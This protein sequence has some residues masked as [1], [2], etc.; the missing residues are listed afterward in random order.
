VKAHDLAW[1]QAEQAAT[2][3]GKGLADAKG[4]PVSQQL[5]LWYWSTQLFRWIM[6][7][8]D[9]AI[10]LLRVLVLT[11]SPLERY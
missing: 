5:R 9:T 4:L 1:S 3:Y 10:G 8:R 6:R 2:E 7:N 11:P